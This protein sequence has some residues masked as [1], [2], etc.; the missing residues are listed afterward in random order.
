MPAT[1]VIR[2]SL[3]D[4]AHGTVVA[5]GHVE[6][7]AS[8]ERDRGGNLEAGPRSETAVAAVT[9]LVGSDRWDRACAPEPM[10][11][12]LGI[13]STDSVVPVVSD[14]KIAPPVESHPTRAGKARLQRHVHRHRKTPAFPFPQRLSAVA[15][16]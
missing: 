4:L 3:L 2:P 10:N 7:A 11:D 5:I 13:D 15:C 8:V 16:G 12:T 14:V 1:V 9:A 6:V